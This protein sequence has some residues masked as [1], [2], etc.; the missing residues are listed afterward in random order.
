[1]I[2]FITITWFA[3]FTLITFYQLNLQIPQNS[4][5]IRVVI[6][7]AA[8]ATGVDVPIATGDD[9]TETPERVVEVVSTLFNNSISGFISILPLYLNQ[10]CTSA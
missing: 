6:D 8:K 10:K 9:S 5:S 3:Q 7:D 4:A 2:T 1:M